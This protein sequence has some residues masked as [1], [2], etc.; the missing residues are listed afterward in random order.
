MGHG[1]LSIQDKGGGGVNPCEPL[2]PRNRVLGGN[3]GLHM[4]PRKELVCCWGFCCVLRLGLRPR[5]SDT[6]PQSLAVPSPLLSFFALARARRYLQTP[7]PSGAV[8]PPPYL[9]AAGP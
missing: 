6:S 2:R 5:G 3:P 7:L 9:P 1:E 8:R 4:W